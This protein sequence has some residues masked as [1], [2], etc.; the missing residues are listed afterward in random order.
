MQEAKH[1]LDS[2]VAVSLREDLLVLQQGIQ[3]ALV[4]TWSDDIVLKELAK[5]LSQLPLSCPPP[6]LLDHL[7]SSEPPLRTAAFRIVLRT[8]RLLVNLW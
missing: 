8:F 3:L 4:L 2:L 5:P 7:L 1:G 6:I